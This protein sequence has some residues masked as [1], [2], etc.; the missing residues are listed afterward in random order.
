MMT[1]T[2][3]T[4]GLCGLLYFILS[5]RVVRLR[6]AHGISLGHGENDILHARIRAHANFAEYVPFVLILIAAIE[7]RV[8]SGSMVLAITGAMLIV[9]R[10]SHIIGMARP[11]SN[12]FRIIG[13]AGTYVILVG[14]SVWA[15]VLAI[16]R[17]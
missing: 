13:A 9:I 16:S 4:A 1:I 2:L 7:S 3:V 11:A 17:V 12:P 8:G 10:L 15:I 6:L 5:V 14:L